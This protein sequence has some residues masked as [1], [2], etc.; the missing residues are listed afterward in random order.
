MRVAQRL[1]LAVIPAV[2]GVLAMAGLAW[3]GQRGR[4]IPEWILLPG[5][6]TAVVSLAMAWHS[7]RYVAQRVE[8]LSRRRA[9]SS[10]PDA[11][12]DELDVLERRITEAE[13]HGETREQAA[14]ARVREYA[15]LLADASV[16]VGR[17]LDEVRLPLHILLASPFGA[18]NENQEEMIGAA[19]TA[20]EAADATLRAVRRVT[21]L[22][23]GRVE[24][25]PEPIRLPDLLAPVLAA[26]ASR[27]E[28]AGAR[29]D[30]DIPPLL[31]PVRVDAGH[32]RE[33]LALVLDGVT[34]LAGTDARVRVAA[35]ARDEGVR[36]RVMDGAVRADEAFPL[37]RRLLHLQGGSLGVTEGGAIEIILPSS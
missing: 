27:L 17:A 21:E 22:D 15:A 7:T 34:R 12:A 10:H 18:L 20:A 2:L 29:L 19:Q 8:S 11:A 9:A 1:F 25:R 4:Q 16:V 3:W 23:A 24:S 26:V 36:V 31:P 30:I 6:L 14:E 5:I 28:R 33:A 35:D 37:A 32:A 13:R